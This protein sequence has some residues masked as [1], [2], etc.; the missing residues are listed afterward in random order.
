[1]ARF[2][3]PG[4]S[5]VITKGVKNGV[6]NRVKKGVKKGGILAHLCILGYFHDPYYLTEDLRQIY[7][8]GEMRG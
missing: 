7:T 4:R 2:Y 5:T 6:K 8:W 3:L 1:M